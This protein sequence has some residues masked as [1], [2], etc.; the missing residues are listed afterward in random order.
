MLLPRSHHNNDRGRA[1]RD[2]I[3]AFGDQFSC[4]GAEIG[5]TAALPRA[6]CDGWCRGARRAPA[7]AP[8]APTCPCDVAWPE[9]DRS[10]DV[11]ARA[12]GA[13]GARRAPLPDWPA[14]RVGRG[15]H[16]RP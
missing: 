7:A 2:S 15:E 12:F 4:G 9:A 3:L 13:T 6:F 16:G 8:A 5:H 14:R 1:L 11:V 10:A